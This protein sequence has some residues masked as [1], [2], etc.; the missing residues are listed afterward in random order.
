M[1]KERLTVV[2]DPE[3]RKKIKIKAIEKNITVSEVV[4]ECVRGVIEKEELEEDIALTKFAEERGKTF[5]QK[6][7]LTHK[8][9]WR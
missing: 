4:E 2:L 6:E 3:I 7:S 8:E 1:S 5:T 9:I